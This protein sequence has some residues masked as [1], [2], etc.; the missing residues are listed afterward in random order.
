VLYCAFFHTVS[1]WKLEKTES[2]EVNRITFVLNV[3]VSQ[4][5]DVYKST[6][7][8]LRWSET[9]LFTL[10]RQSYSTI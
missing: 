8:V 9:K 2:E 4:F 5:I 1:L 6:K 7:K 10:I 3:V